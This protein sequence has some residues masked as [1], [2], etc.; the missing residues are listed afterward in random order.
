MRQGPPGIRD[1]T[2]D[3]GV[4]IK[5]DDDADD[6]DHGQR[7]A[8]NDHDL[9][10]GGIALDDA[11]EDVLGNRGTGD[12]QI[13]RS[14]GHRSRKNTGHHHAAHEGGQNHLGDDDEDV[15]SSRIGAEIGGQHGA[16][17]EAD[18]QGAHHGDD[19]PHH[20][21]DARLANLL[22]RT[23]TQEAHEHLRH[24]E[25]AKA[26]S[27]GG[28]D[29]EDAE[30]GRLTEQRLITLDRLQARSSIHNGR[31]ELPA[32]QEAGDVL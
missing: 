4:L 13:R 9:T 16:S 20:G 10:I 27:Q 12:E 2:E 5:G 30:I 24:A 19:D 32:V 3:D 28:D 14:R 6:H 26:P 31:G 17:D 25:V 1:D 23:D 15:L 21:D 11:A 29:G 18:A 8:G 7:D 22:S